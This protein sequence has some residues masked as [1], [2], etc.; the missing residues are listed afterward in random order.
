MACMIL[1]KTVLNETG[2][3][4]IV[5]MTLAAPM[6]ARKAE[7]GQFIMFMADE[8]SERVPL[9]I[10][11][12][13]PR[14]GSV[15]IIFQEAGF[16]TRL[17]GSK[18]AGDEIYSFVGPLG[19]PAHIN[20]VG[21]VCVM[22][23]GVGIAEILPI[24]RAFKEVGNRVVAILGARNKDLLILR[25]EV[26]KEADQSI[27]ATNDGSMGLQGL[28]TDAFA[29]LTEKVNQVY[30]IGPVPMMKAVCDMTKQKAIP[31]VVCLNSIMIDGT[32]M[33]GSCRLT[34]DGEMKF[35]CVD[36]PDFDGHKVDFA[37]LMLRQRRFNEQEKRI[38]QDHACR[39]QAAADAAEKKA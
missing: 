17:L 33:C 1:S 14:T 19:K 31:T 29:A 8:N 32:G 34:Y 18:N 5:R 12:A 2:G 23:G 10:S 35:C 21:T 6:I 4:R 3:V 25:D 30:C 36:G 9:T 26:A 11:D 39:M 16:S 27:Y 24:I 22:A 28:V 7:A 38:V 13:D 15:T 20:Y 37:E